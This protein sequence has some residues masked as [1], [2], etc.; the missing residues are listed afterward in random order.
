MK[1]ADFIAR[2]A[3]SAVEEMRRTRIPASLTIA[4][5]ILESN[6][7][8]S[9]LTQQANNLFGMKGRGPAG[10]VTMPTREYISGQWMT[11]QAAFRA[12]NT[13]EESIPDHSTLILNGTRDK[14]TRYH[15]VL[16]EDFRTACYEI[17]RGGYATDPEYPEKLI[18]LITTYELWK[19]DEQGNQGNKPWNNHGENSGNNQGNKQGKEHQILELTKMQQTMLVDALKK[20]HDPEQGPL[21]DRQWIDKAEQ[22]QLTLSELCWLNLIILSR[23]SRVDI[24]EGKISPS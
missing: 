17:W 2:I 14:P 12:Y 20:W 22:G 19:F 9:K 3:P 13:W 5:A 16:G 11:V 7:G 21:F 4:Q 15:G 24:Q 1:P 10:S 23:I 8:E 6:W 18:G